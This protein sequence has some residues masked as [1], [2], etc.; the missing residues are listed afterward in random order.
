MELRFH[1]GV[2]PKTIHNSGDRPGVDSGLRTI[3]A[4]NMFDFVTQLIIDGNAEGTLFK[5]GDGA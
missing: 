4:K 5:Y 2:H 1:I 3:L